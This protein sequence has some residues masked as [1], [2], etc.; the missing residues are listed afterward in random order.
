VVADAVVCL[1]KLV[2]C[3]LEACRLLKA[4]YLSLKSTPSA[5]SPEL[6]HDEKDDL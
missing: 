3:Q 2:V 4:H 5:Q 1:R 6:A